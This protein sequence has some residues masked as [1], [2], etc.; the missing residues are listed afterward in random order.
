[1]LN[2]IVYFDEEDTRIE[3]EDTIVA[4][5]KTMEANSDKLFDALNNMLVQYKGNE[6]KI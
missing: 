5:L 2:S 6:Q 1:V 3:N 4:N